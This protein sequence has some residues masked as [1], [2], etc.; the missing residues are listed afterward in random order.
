MTIFSCSENEQP[1]VKWTYQGEQQ[2][3]INANEY[4]F[5]GTEEYSEYYIRVSMYS[6]PNQKQWGQ[7]YR[8]YGSSFNARIHTVPSG[9]TYV[10]FQADRP[11][12]GAMG[13]TSRYWQR[14]GDYES[15]PDG[16]YALSGG[17]VVHYGGHIIREERTRVLSRTQIDEYVN[18]IVKNNGETVFSRIESTFP[19]VV[20]ECVANQQCPED[21]C[22]VVCGDTICCYGSDGI[23]VTSFPRT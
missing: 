17:N 13:P 20:T 10:I 2:Q 19:D 11:R 9:A 23:A 7:Y 16:Y 8:A 1:V 22:E 12:G 18:F 14:P 6:D 15:I 4:I 5:E 21:T 3:Q